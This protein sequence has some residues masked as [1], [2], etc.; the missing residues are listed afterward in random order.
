VS[1]FWNRPLGSKLIILLSIAFVAI[2]FAPWQRP[3]AASGP[4]GENICGWRTA[5]SGSDFGTFAALLAIAILVWELLPIFAP[6]LSM[7]GWPTAVIT[8]I[9]GVALAICVLVK[10]IDDNQFQT[11]WAWIGLAVA[12]ATMLVA[13][14]RVRY[15]WSIRG[16]E[17]P[18]PAVPAT[19]PAPERDASDA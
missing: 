7:R 11:G 10:M 12:L 1:S 5:Y 15:R 9:L 2:S 17:Q 16:R 3:C 8:A 19:P 18:P 6:R 13:L 4:T 14:I